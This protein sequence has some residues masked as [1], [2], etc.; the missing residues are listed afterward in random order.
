MQD[1]PVHSFMKQT[2]ITDTFQPSKRIN[3]LN[4]LPIKARDQATELL[5]FI[6]MKI[7]SEI[8]SWDKHFQLY[9]NN[10]TIPKSSFVDIIK[11]LYGY[12]KMWN[13]SY[14]SEDLGVAEN[15]DEYFRLM[16]K[17]T[18]EFYFLLKK[19]LPNKNLT[20]FF[21][22]HAPYINNLLRFY[23]IVLK[24]TTDDDI[25][26]LMNAEK[27]E[28]EAQREE[29]KQLEKE[30]NFFQDEQEE[31]VARNLNKDG[32]LDGSITDEVEEFDES[33]LD[34]E[35]DHLEDVVD[36][37]DEEI[38]SDIKE[39][40]EEKVKNQMERY[41]E[42]LRK[43]KRTRKPPIVYTPDSDVGHKYERKTIGR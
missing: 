34:D 38:M 25:T 33:M 35:F 16:P 29:E 19:Y 15:V 40:E 18:D 43:S 27:E 17:G 7:P 30:R 37:T 14:T 24:D 10:R 11:Y 3:L 39:M 20:Q 41:V 9:I 8:L 31:R 13:S 42:K 32:A 2:K 1:E 5:D 4:A 28:K 6:K 36:I 22:F 26:I 21:N 23:Y 12:G